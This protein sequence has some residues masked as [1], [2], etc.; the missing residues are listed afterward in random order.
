VEKWKRIGERARPRRIPALIRPGYIIDVDGGNPEAHPGCQH[1]RL[2][3]SPCS[4]KYAILDERDQFAR[5]LGNINRPHRVLS[6]VITKF[7]CSP[8]NCLLLLLHFISR[9][10]E[11]IESPQLWRI[12]A[13]VRLVC[14]NSTERIRVKVFPK[15]F[16]C[17]FG[18]ASFPA[19][20][21]GSSP[22][23]P[24]RHA[25]I[26]CHALISLL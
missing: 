15:N 9:F 1:C 18:K 26:F 16:N 17:P 7:I 5:L 2:V 14:V 25:P 3:N 21:S 4:S 23:L 20:V 22:R 12:G 6:C 19:R 10:T 13:P 8:R 24:R 11:K